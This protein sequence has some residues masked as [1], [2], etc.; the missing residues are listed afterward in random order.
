MVSEIGD[1][2]TATHHVRQCKSMHTYCCNSL[3]VV[4]IKQGRLGSIDAILLKHIEGGLTPN[5]DNN[6][7]YHGHRV[8][9]T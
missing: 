4:P 8:G 9:V 6:N 2:I 5:S 1:S 7:S 3:L